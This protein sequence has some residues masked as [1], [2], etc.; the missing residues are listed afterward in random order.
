MNKTYFGLLGALGVCAVSVVDEA[1]RVTWKVVQLFILG[2][3]F[4]VQL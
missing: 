2:E 1:A 4:A 3:P